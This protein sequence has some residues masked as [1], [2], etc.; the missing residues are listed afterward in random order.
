M[1]LLDIMFGVQVTVPRRLRDKSVHDVMDT[2]RGRPEAQSPGGGPRQNTSERGK[3]GL[4]AY[5]FRETIG[6]D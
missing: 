3:G 5:P 2:E 4:I 6:Q 1:M